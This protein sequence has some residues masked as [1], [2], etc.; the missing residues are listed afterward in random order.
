M[1]LKFVYDK[2]QIIPEEIIQLT[3]ENLIENLKSTVAN[4]TAISLA[5]ELPNSLSVPHMMMG[6][7]K[8]LLSLGLA[9]DYKFKELEEALKAKACL[10]YTS[11]SPRDKRQSRMPS[12]A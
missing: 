7:F 3:P 11:P 5:S 10:L 8:D 12:S 4:M 1:E 6:C 9:T 2:G